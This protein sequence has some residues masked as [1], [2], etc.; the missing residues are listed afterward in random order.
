MADSQPMVIAGV[1]THAA[2]HHA[3]VLDGCGRLLGSAEF[4]ATSQ[5]Y[6]RLLGWLASHGTIGQVGVEGTGSYGAGLTR[7]LLE[8]GVSV[9]EVSRPNRRLRRQHGKSDPI[10]AEAAARAVLAGEA[11]AIP[12]PH[13][14]I[15]EAI[16]LL[17]V[18]RT[19][20]VKAR[21]AARNQL[22]DLLVTAPAPLRE[23]LAGLP[24]ATQTRACLGLQPDLR[25][26]HHPYQATLQALRTVAQRI[27]DLDREITTTSRQLAKLVTRAAP[28]TT[29][30]LGLG[31]EHAGQLLVTAGDNPDRLRSDACFAALCAAAP[32]PASSGKTT[33]HRLNPG[34]DRDANRALHLIA[35]VR[36]RWCPRTRAYAARRTTQG[37]S[38]REI[39]RCLKRYIAREV[40][41]T[42]RADLAALSAAT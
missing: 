41:H 22:R 42:L 27:H 18:T 29:A 11:T 9:V 12:K 20:A 14:G 28:H 16:R 5:G 1:D 19:G 40:Y 34:G 3:A 24:R 13:T 33:R 26:L 35:V 17:R 36:L 8:Q 6:Q 21:T 39:I 2:T 30:L 7:S 10:D 25:H 31:I 23:E 15:V 38:K 4:P 37:L 32:I